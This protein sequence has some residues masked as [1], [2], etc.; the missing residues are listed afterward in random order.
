MR[1]RAYGENMS[2]AAPAQPSPQP[3]S[4]PQKTGYEVARPAGRCAA[5]NASIEPGA[6]L[7]I[8]GELNGWYKVK[9]PESLHELRPR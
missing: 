7:A 9:A 5:C 1:K 3:Q 4:Q 6:K 2:M 8:V